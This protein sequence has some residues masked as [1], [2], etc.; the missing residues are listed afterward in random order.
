[1]KN[2]L[3]Y[4]SKYFSSKKKISRQALI[5]VAFLFFIFLIIL[6]VM[7][8]AFSNS[9]EEKSRSIMFDETS[10]KSELRF[11]WDLKEYDILEGK[12]DKY[13]EQKL[14]KKLYEN[15]LVVKQYILLIKNDSHGIA[16]Y[17][18]KYRKKISKSDYYFLSGYKCYLDKDYKNSLKYF[19]KISKDEQIYYDAAVISGKI[20]LEKNDLNS[21]I[22]TLNGIRNKDSLIFYDLAVLYSLKSDFNLAVSELERISKDFIDEEILDF[23]PS[24][25]LVRSY[26]E[27]GDYEKASN[28]IKSLGDYPFLID[29]YLYNFILVSY[30]TGNIDNL[31]NIY[32]E[33]IQNDNYPPEVYQIY[34]IVNFFNGDYQ[35]AIE[36]FKS[37]KDKIFISKDSY[38]KMLFLQVYMLDKKKAYDD[39]NELLNFNILSSVDA[40][41]LPF[42]LSIYKDAMIGTGKAEQLEVTL[43]SLLKS[44]NE[45]LII[46]QELSDLYI[47][48]GNI[49]KGISLLHDEKIIGNKPAEY[50]LI[51][52]K[53]YIA[54]K[55]YENASKILDTVSRMDIDSVSKDK[56]FSQLAYFSLILKKYDDFE[57]NYSMI[58]ESQK[59]TPDNQLL[60][61]NYAISTR[62]YQ[63][64]IDYSS[65]LL[66][67]YPDDKNMLFYLGIA[68]YETKQFSNS[69]PVFAR[70][71]EIEKNLKSKAIYAI[72]LGNSYAYLGN[73]QESLFFYKQAAVWDPDQ[74]YSML[75]SKMIEDNKFED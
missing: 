16:N 28:N 39:I 66:E 38:N 34:Y 12:V 44:R 32:V 53:L 36:I 59:N 18:E 27:L 63:K 56:V 49:D 25:L 74:N 31:E 20:Y 26:I 29:T 6:F 62:D 69:I 10:I 58:S 9:N 68:Y 60:Y 22:N 7:I 2:Q 19:S 47:L 42:F 13:L 64:I 30:K 17:L 75:N 33:L 23:K 54:K 50:Y 41:Y 46:L 15:L 43:F 21:A 24:L 3:N 72:Y 45:K 73:I 1:M 61:L 57:R 55:D 11:F 48:S 5:V 65:S 40:Q 14:P 70:L 51:L 67:K 37:K 35:K 4:K 8:M 71:I 52:A